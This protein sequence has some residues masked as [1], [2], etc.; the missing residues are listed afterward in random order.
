MTVLG[1]I[2]VRWASTRLPGKPLAD[3]GGKPM[4]WWVW[5]AATRARTLDRVIVA[6]DDRRILDAAR[7]FG[8]E[9][10]MTPRT[11]RSGSDRVAEVARRVKS[12]L[13]VNIQGDEPFLKPAAIDR[14]VRPLLK[15][16][17]WRMG[18]LA[19]PLESAERPNANMVKVWVNGTG[20]AKDFARTIPARWRR[21]GQETRPYKHLGLYVYRRDLLLRLTRWPQTSRERRER[22]EQL[23]ALEH[24]VAIHVA[25]VQHAGRGVDTPRDLAWARR[26]IRR[27]R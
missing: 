14:A 1:V 24:G 9:A 16:R 23:R 8:A 3:I 21:A 20:A 13:V 12:D 2:P 5:R 6:T 26:R 7:G 17:R 22:L 18:T 15:A 11:C 4:L 25:E 19:A 27:T 10:V